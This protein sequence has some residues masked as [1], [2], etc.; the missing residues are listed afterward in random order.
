MPLYLPLCILQL[1][2]PNRVF[3]SYSYFG[4]QPLTNYIHFRASIEKRSEYLDKISKYDK[5]QIY[6]LMRVV[7]IGP[8]AQIEGNLMPENYPARQFLR[9]ADKCFGVCIVN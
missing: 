6:I 5:E 1:P 3:I 8:F 2:Q 9:K 4:V 7:Q